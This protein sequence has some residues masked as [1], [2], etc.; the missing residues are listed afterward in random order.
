MSVGA[1]VT[2]RTARRLFP[3]AV[4]LTFWGLAVVWIRHETVKTSFDVGQ[5]RV[6]LQRL[7][8]DN[9]RLRSRLE[10]LKSPAR[11]ERLA[12][13]VFH[14]GP[15]NKDQVISITEPTTGP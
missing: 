14:F 12:K 1:R 4:F 2:Q 3:V 10:Q 11:L 5:S 6:E 8:E 7:Q 15:P 9:V 13:E